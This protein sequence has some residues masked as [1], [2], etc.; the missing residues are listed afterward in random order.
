MTLDPS[1]SWRTPA[2]AVADRQSFWT[3][4][5]A[6]SCLFMS[7]EHV[8]HVGAMLKG[9]FEDGSRLHDC[10]AELPANPG[11]VLIEGDR[12]TRQE[13]VAVVV[14]GFTFFARPLL[15]RPL[16]W[17]SKDQRLSSLPDNL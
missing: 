8:A 5:L 13:N 12:A 9:G 17:W 7:M 15:E 16:S 11:F 4:G 14:I 6:G 10:L 2:N 3:K 1:R